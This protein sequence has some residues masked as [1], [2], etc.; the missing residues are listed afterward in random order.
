MGQ[1]TNRIL[2]ALIIGASA[3]LSI[4][5]LVWFVRSVWD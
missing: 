4:A 3:A 5:L 2:G 1:M